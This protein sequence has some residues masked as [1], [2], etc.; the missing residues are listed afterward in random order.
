M[1]KFSL[2]LKKELVSLVIGNK[3]GIKKAAKKFGVSHN[4]AKRWVKMYQHHGES[5]LSMKSGTYSGEFKTNAVEYMHKNHLSIQEASACWGIPGPT[6]LARWE[7]IYQEEGPE[8]LFLERRGRHNI[9][10]KPL[11]EK[12][13][14]TEKDLL[15]EIEKLKAEVAYLKKYNALVQAKKESRTKKKQK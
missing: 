15:D 7:R 4:L 13:N 6:T 3:C 11:N 9:M 8:A 5:G 14:K 12:Q 2:E 1:E 10:K